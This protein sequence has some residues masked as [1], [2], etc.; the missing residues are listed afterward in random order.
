MPAEHLLEVREQADLYSES[1]AQRDDEVPEIRELIER[2]LPARDQR[3]DAEVR[4]HQ[5]EE[6]EGAETE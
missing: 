3:E 5:A 6:G 2:K 1:Y 4:T